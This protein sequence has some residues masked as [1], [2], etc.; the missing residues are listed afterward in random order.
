MN[1][2]VPWWVSVILAWLPFIVLVGSATWMIATLRAALHTPD[3]R[4]LAKVIDDYVH[5]MQRANDLKREAIAGQPSQ[6]KA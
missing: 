1:N 5:E 2:D 6:P 3:G 4:S